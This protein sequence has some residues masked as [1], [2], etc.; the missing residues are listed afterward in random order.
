M[1][2]FGL[3]HIA[4]LYSNINVKTIA[5]IFYRL[6]PFIA[7]LQRTFRHLTGAKQRTALTLYYINQVL[8]FDKCQTS[9][10]YYFP[11]GSESTIFRQGRCLALIYQIRIIVVGQVPNCNISKRSSHIYSKSMA[12]VSTLIF[13]VYNLN[14]CRFEM[15]RTDR[16]LTAIYKVSSGLFSLLLCPYWDQIC[17]SGAGVLL[18][19]FLI[20]QNQIFYLLYTVPLGRQTCSHK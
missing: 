12:E 18:Q 3:Y 9:V 17:C 4:N 8:E 7:F 11:F 5:L 2:Q 13:S 10:L 14:D 15:L 19:I 16:Y 6:L 20:I 1:L